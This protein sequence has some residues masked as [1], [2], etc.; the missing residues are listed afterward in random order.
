[1][2]PVQ[3]LQHMLNHIARTQAEAPRLAETGVFDEATLEALMIFQRDHAL[4]VT[5]IAD[6][7][8]WDSV[9]DAYTISFALFGPPPPLH[10]FPNGEHSVKPSERAAE[11]RIAQAMLT[12]LLP[13]LAEFEQPLSD[14]VNS[15]ATVR[16]LKRLQSVSGLPETGA[17]DRITWDVLVRLYRA[18]ITRR[19]VETFF[20]P[21]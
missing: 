7:S 10:A 5:G 18:L 16:N 21:V 4:S 15:G 17:L 19:S 9:R 3:S 2:N 14:G 11:V 13:L 12:E 6:H 8:T 20:L 1:M